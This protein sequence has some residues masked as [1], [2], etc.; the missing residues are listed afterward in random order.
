MTARTRRRLLLCLVLGAITLPVELLL[1]PVAR[2]PDARQAAD[3]WVAGLSPAELRDATG[4][5]DAYP[6][7]YRRA[8]MG[9]LTAE[10]RARVWRGQFQRFLD[11]HRELT[12]EQR[13]VVSGAMAL[14]TPEAF[15]PPLSPELQAKITASFDE[16]TR[17][18]PGQ[19]AKELFVTLG[20]KEA[21]NASALPLSQRLADRIRSWRV[22]SADGGDCNCNVDIDTCDIWPE[23]DWL[24]CSEQYTC[25]MDLSWPMCGPLWSWACTG[26]CRVLIWPKEM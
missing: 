12:S 17:V 19:A 20:P 18:L 10:D 24:Q 11:A 4:Q 8:L 7:L 14:I 13:A 6:A 23:P 16:A 22:T 3:A 25:D 9:A 5:I 15:R 26:W 21:T 1:L 2:T